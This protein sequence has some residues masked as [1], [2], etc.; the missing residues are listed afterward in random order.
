MHIDRVFLLRTG[1]MVGTV[2][3]LGACERE[4]TISYSEDV[5]PIL[6][7][8]CLECHTAGGTGAEK[9]GFNMD[10]YAELMEGTR[11]GPMIEPGESG[12]SNLYLLVAGRADPSIQMPHG[13]EKL[14]RADIETIRIW[15]DQGALN[16]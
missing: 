11:Y 12:A 4:L 13:K 2:L 5:R 14:A 1:I 9:S 16:N 7:A 6:E 15:I 10:S 3:L 8:N